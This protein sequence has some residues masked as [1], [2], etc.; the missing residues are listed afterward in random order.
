MFSFCNLVCDRITV[1][2]RS[3]CSGGDSGRSSSPMETES[4]VQFPVPVTPICFSASDLRDTYLGHHDFLFSSPTLSIFSF[5]LVGTACF[6]DTH[7]LPFVFFSLGICAK[8]TYRLSVFVL[9]LSEPNNQKKT[10][11]L[12]LK[13]RYKIRS[14]CWTKP[15][16]RKR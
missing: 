6:C 14:R 11:S 5:L 10:G 13:W 2:S 15:T 4:W 3:L 7:L 8:L 16:K 9:H 1:S 12:R